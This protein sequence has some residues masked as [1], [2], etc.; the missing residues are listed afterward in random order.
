[1]KISKIKLMEVCGTHTMAIARI[2]IKKILPS[3]I[4]LISG[5]GCP[6]CVTT[7]E[8]VQRAIEISRKKNVIMTTFGDMIR[9]P[10]LQGSLE[11]VKTMGCDVR[12][13]YS[14]LDALRIAEENQDKKVVFMGVGFETTSPTAAATILEA[15]KRDIHNFFVLS[16]FK[17]IFPAL[18]TIAKSKRLKIDGFI[19][20]GHVSVITGSAPYE[21]IAKH[22]K[23]PCVI[24]GFEA[25]DI[26]R[27]IEMLIEQIRRGR[28]CVEIAYK[29]AVKKQGNTTARRVLNS[30]FERRDSEWRGIGIIK[31][32]GLKL[33]RKYKS[34]DAEAEFNVKLPQ[35][36]QKKGCICGEVIQ[37][38]KSPADCRLFGKVC[39]PQKPL[40][41]CMVS[42]EGSCA[43][44]YKYGR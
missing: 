28:H 43:A 31:K 19:C 11:E 34:F 2:G 15:E 27:G 8:D 32:G 10:G 40:G 36:K 9:V 42:S 12:V 20:P 14:C 18:E 22:Y 21:K 35:A 16:N 7:E 1:M 25:A 44:Y 6:V 37:G 4:E 39:T 3:D 38:A 33:R 13:V 24:T 30:V 26:M 5:P 23:K 17:L 29:R 41:P